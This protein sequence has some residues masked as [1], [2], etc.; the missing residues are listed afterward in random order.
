MGLYARR[1]IQAIALI[2]G[3]A[4]I[5]LAITGY[6]TDRMFHAVLCAAVVAALG[7]IGAELMRHDRGVIAAT[8]LVLETLRESE[9]ERS[10]DPVNG[11]RSVHPMGG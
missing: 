10:K 7:G 11:F 5:H 4:G 6:G 3:G 1:L 9:E 8:R 2:L